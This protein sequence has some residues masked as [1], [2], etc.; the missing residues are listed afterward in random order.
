MPG[1]EISPVNASGAGKISSTNDAAGVV[2]ESFP[3][4]PGSLS[5]PSS[6]AASNVGCSR[7]GS[8]LNT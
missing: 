3:A 6:E 2:S 5:I 7:Q 1:K 8:L 4:N